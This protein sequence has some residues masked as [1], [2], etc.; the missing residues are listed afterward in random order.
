[1]QRVLPPLLFSLGLAGAV[2]FWPGAV[3]APL[4]LRW[5]VLATMIPLCLILLGNRS[6]PLPWLPAA[7]VAGAAISLA[8]TPDVYSGIDDLAHLVILFAA[9]WLG[10]SVRDLKPLWLGLSIGVGVSAAFVMAQWGFDS[11]VVSQTARPGG[12]FGNK[13]FC[14]EAAM[15][16]VIACLAMKS[17]LRWALTAAALFVVVICSSKAVFAGLAVAASFWMLPRYT[18]SAFALLVGLVGLAI[19]L[20]LVD[21]E[22][23][24]YRLPMW[25]AALS[26]LRLLGHGIGSYAG[27]Y[28]AYEHAHSEPLQ[29]IYELGLLAILP[30]VIFWKALEGWRGET[31]GFILI[32]VGA[33][34]LWSFPLH[35]PLTVLAAAA[36]AGH[37]AHA[38]SV[39]VERRDSVRLAFGVGA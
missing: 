10:A 13:N 9:F 28:P 15:V 35:M 4:T 5:A 6:A 25:Q 12:L 17:R 34:S 18:K 30:A 2:A 26:D 32:A 37:L 27:A 7:F 29:Y 20:F 11:E 31:E 33:V 38:R 23:V 1:M 22:S 14:A 21:H 8:W 3:D 19:L 24:T 16:A 36:A 39:M